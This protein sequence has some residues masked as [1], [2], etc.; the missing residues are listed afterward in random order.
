MLI[1]P[2]LC[3]GLTGPVDSGGARADAGADAQNGRVWAATL[4]LAVRDAQSH[5]DCSFIQPALELVELSRARL[6]A[7]LRASLHG[8]GSKSIRPS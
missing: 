7:P 1:A 6:G 8:F 2:L 5:G 4:V 3:S